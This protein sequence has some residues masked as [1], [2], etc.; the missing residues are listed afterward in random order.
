MSLGSDAKMRLSIE[1]L[2]LYNFIL[3][4]AHVYIVSNG[5]HEHLKEACSDHG[6]FFGPALQE[7]VI[8]RGQSNVQRHMI[9]DQTCYLPKLCSQVHGMVPVS[10]SLCILYVH[11]FAPPLTALLFQGWWFYS[12]WACYDH[13]GPERPSITAARSPWSKLWR[14]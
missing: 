1:K 13:P 6:H 2:V 9:Q 4:S 11:M 8:W 5:V 3:S 7:H 14:L 10:F 12:R